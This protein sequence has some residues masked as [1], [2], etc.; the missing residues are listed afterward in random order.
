MVIPVLE[1]VR[2]LEDMIVPNSWNMRSRSDWEKFF[3]RPQMYKLAPLIDS[4]LG[5]ANETYLYV[6]RWNQVYEY[7]DIKVIVIIL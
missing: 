3:G 6:K 4:E 1:S 5:L 7:T 2:I